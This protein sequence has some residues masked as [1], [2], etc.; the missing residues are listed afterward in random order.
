[1]NKVDVTSGMSEGEK[2]IKRSQERRELN[3]AKTEH[4][5]QFSTGV[6]VPEGC[7]FSDLTEEQR[8]AYFSNNPISRV[9][10]E[11]MTMKVKEG[12]PEYV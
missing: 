7:N 4:A 1:M 10:P 2:M 12:V 6:K 9:I 11:N 8:K 3:K 5:A